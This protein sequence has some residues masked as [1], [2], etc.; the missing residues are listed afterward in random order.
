VVGRNGSTELPTDLTE[1]TRN[2]SKP[3]SCKVHCY[4]FKK[5]KLSSIGNRELQINYPVV[6]AI[7]SE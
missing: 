4:A 1:T 6:L 2:S 5:Q 3:G 7:S